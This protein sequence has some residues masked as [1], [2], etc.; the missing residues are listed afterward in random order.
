MVILAEIKRV[1][2]D[3][4]IWLALINQETPDR[5]QRCQNVLTMARNGEM[6]IWTSAL[7]L[8]EVFK[9]KCD[10]KNTGLP[11]YKDIE[12]E[13]YILQD[14]LTVVQ[15]DYDIGVKA[16]QLLRSFSVLKKPP[17]GI[18]LATAVEHDLDEFHTF[19]RENLLPLNDKIKRKDGVP[20]RICHPPLPIQGTLQLESTQDNHP[21]QNPKPVNQDNKEEQSASPPVPAVAMPS[22]NSEDNKPVASQGE[23]TTSDKVASEKESVVPTNKLS[24]SSP[25]LKPATNE[26]AKPEPMVNTP[27]ATPAPAPNGSASDPDTAGPGQDR[28]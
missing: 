27:T 25:D 14:Y 2:W 17:D 16:R 18:H 12:F 21:L 15:V 5:V 20:L 19:D 13:E 22:S 10:D 4:C 24:A 8:A 28:R 11:E 7:T 1:Y 23:G 9:K 6:E 3:A 26:T